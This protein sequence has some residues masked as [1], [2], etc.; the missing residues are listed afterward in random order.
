MPHLKSPA[1]WE[2]SWDTHEMLPGLAEVCFAQTKSPRFAK[3]QLWTIYSKK[4]QLYSNTSNVK[5]TFGFQ[6]R[7][8]FKFLLSFCYSYHFV[9]GFRG[10]GGGSLMPSVGDCQKLL[11]CAMEPMPAALRG[12][13][14]W[15]RLSPSVMGFGMPEGGCDPVVRPPWS[16]SWQD[17]WSHGERTAHVGGVHGV[18]SPMAGPHAGGGEECEDSSSCGG[19]SPKTM[20]DKLTTAPFPVHLDCCRGGDK[21]NLE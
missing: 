2:L 5:R 1:H 20:C 9:S 21:E 10:R 18:R 16:S 19:R 11:L 8:A 13:R 15:P 17:L 14:G 12:T 4:T 6:S 7:A 3:S